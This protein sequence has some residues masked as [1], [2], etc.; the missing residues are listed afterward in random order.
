MLN[1]I[2]LFGCTCQQEALY[3]GLPMDKGVSGLTQSGSRVEKA[4]PKWL[5]PVVDYV[6]LA[7]YFVAYYFFTDKDLVAATKVIL[8]ATAAAVLLSLVVARRVPVLPLVTSGFVLFFA[9]LTVYFEDAT[10]IKMKPTIVQILFAGLLWVSLLLNRLWLKRIFNMAF[11]LPDEIWRTL[12]WRFIWFFLASAALNEF[13]WR[14]LSEE[15][16]F[17]FKVFG[18]TG[19]TFVFILSQMPMISKNAVEHEEED[20]EEDAG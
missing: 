17:N 8:I 7:A 20:G 9:G 10:Y 1:T 13:V 11:H 4:E 12:T 3:L 15:F 18:L 16:W 19:L 5:K 2:G 14:S 6:P